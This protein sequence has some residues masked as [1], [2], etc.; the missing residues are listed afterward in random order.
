MKEQIILRYFPTG[1]KKRRILKSLG[2]K[3]E[4]PIEEI[5]NLIYNLSYK[6]LKQCI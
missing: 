2:L 5:N 3:S 1:N 4:G 6:Q